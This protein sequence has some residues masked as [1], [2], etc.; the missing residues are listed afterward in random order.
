MRFNRIL[1][2]PQICISGYNSFASQTAWV[3]ILCFRGGTRFSESTSFIPCNKLMPDQ[4]HLT[5][6]NLLFGI[7]SLQAG[8]IDEAQL[9]TAMKRWAFEKDRSIDVILLEQGV[10]T[11][12]Q[13]ELVQSMV[14][15]QLKLHE[16]DT[17]KALASFGSVELATLSIREAVDDSDLHKTIDHLQTLN[18]TVNQTRK[19]QPQRNSNKDAF[20]KSGSRFRV[21]RS[22]ARGGL[23]E[24]YV[25]K[26]EELNRQVA[27]KEIQKQ[28]ADQDDSR[29]R[30]VQEAEITGGLE[31]PGI[32]PVYG[33]GSYEDGR[34]YYAMRFIDGDSL[35][36][37]ISRF[38]SANMSVAERRLELRVLLGRFV[39]VCQA[40]G[41]AHSRGVL[42]RDL[43][44]GNIMLGKYGET[45]VV[46]WGLA[47]V[48]GREESIAASDA[49][50]TLHVS[51]E[52]NVTPTV[53]G[54][55]IGTPAYMS[56]EQATGAISDLGPQSDVYSLGATLFHLLTGT[57]PFVDADSFAI[58]KRIQA[59]DIPSP[60]SID[61]SIPS[62]LDAICRRAMSVLPSD[63]YD[64]T[65][66]LGDDIER[67]L[68]DEPVSAMNEPFIT[69][70]RRWAR[71]HPAIMT[72]AA[73]MVLIST[74]GLSI[75]ST[76]VSGLNSKLATANRRLETAIENETSAKNR[77]I[78]NA[79][80][81]KRNE[82]QAAENEVIAREQS[83][84]AVET[85]QS[86]IFD[87]QS[88]L[89]NLSGASEVRR[90]LLNTSIEKLKKVSTAF[91]QKSS[92]DRNAAAAFNEMGDLILR[93]GEPSETDS[94]VE[95]ALQFYQRSLEIFERI[96]ESDPEN[97]G[98]QRD[99]SVPHEKMGN[100]FLQTGRTKEALEQ[101]K[102]CLSIRQKLA[103]S[104]PQDPRAQ[105][106]L[107]YAHNKI[108]DIHFQ[109][110]E[111]DSA[112]EEFQISL[113][114][115]K[116]LVENS[117]EYSRA[118]LNLSVAHDKL[119]TVLLRNQQIDEALDNYRSSLEIRETI[120]V[121]EPNSNQA[122][123]NLSTAFNKIGEVLLVSGKP[124][125]ALTEFE[126]SLEIRKRLAN[127][128]PND[129]V[130]QQNVAA[131]QQ[132][133]GD[134]LLKLAKVDDAVQSYQ[135][136][137]NILTKLSKLNP[138]D[139]Q[140]KRRLVISHVK[141]GNAFQVSK[142]WGLAH[143]QYEGAQMILER[144]VE[145]KQLLSFS[146]ATLPVVR[147]GIQ[148]TEQLINKDVLEAK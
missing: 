129:L 135:K 23:G 20:V 10:V 13:V 58:V 145:Q 62:S 81:A 105:S 76:V 103:T 128:D 148:Q 108:G 80:L 119:G 115:S 28:Y 1:R 56:P 107:S 63:R 93:F 8:V 111:L 55:V 75:F 134:A 4:N 83:Q 72:S 9:V 24:V 91:L 140:A 94:P 144:M 79:E 136:S 69:R 45:L 85:L 71:K 25:A 53:M 74:I 147:N 61:K 78:A 42:H 118:F 114:I 27:L 125:E 44:P 38:H 130:L 99:L 50:K 97:F 41:Y 141:Q 64:T 90:Q 3:G 37:A 89:R 92:V 11:V 35:K 138:T 139:V 49:E 133:L 54:Q 95:S 6:K 52:S 26:D 84:L 143:E 120:A 86:V 34:P 30:F 113:A 77:A 102:N 70:V 43:K 15:A 112:I 101:F 122:K 82:A 57:A 39:D 96:A 21:L 31:H 66:S 16:N 116:K 22:H 17:E 121:R 123:R 46:D 36:E 59:G 65:Q 87:V 132:Y 60:R 29:S 146:E 33:L 109:V 51:A 7:L 19:S 98:A 88:G 110:G 68:A 14:E 117:P 40:I 67:F 131:S 137:F 2:P 124:K 142:Q 106:D 18:P 47:K 5:D 127:S 32:I 73:A 48:K 104:Q 100:V 12:G 126:Q